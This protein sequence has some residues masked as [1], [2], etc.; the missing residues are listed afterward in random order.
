MFGPPQGGVYS[1]S[2]QATIY[3]IGCVILTNINEIQKIN[4]STP[5]VHYLPCVVLNNLGRDKEGE[6]ST[7]SS[8]NPPLVF[9]DDIFIP[10]SEPSGSIKCTVER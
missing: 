8:H 9:E 7:P 3:D 10:T 1:E 6:D 5:N 4:I 2:L